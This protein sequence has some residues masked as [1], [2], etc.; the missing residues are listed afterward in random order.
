M[1]P[2]ELAQR[3]VSCIP[4]VDAAY[5]AFL[6]LVDL[7]GLDEAERLIRSANAEREVN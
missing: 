6:E 3:I 1:S 5:P 7:V 2:H 4:D